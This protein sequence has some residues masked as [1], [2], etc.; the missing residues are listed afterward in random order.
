MLHKLLTNGAGPATEAGYPQGGWPK[1]VS[2][3]K[4]MRRTAFSRAVPPVLK[5]NN[6][7]LTSTIGMTL[8]ELL[9]VLSVIA[10]VV[11]LSTPALVRYSGQ[12]RLKS[13]VRQVVGLLSLV[14]S[15]SVSSP[16]GHTVSIDLERRELS[17]V[18][19]D[20]GE[21]LEQIVR[22]PRGLEVAVEAG[23]EALKP[24]ELVFQPN[25][26][27]RGR[28]VS[29]IL[30]DKDKDVTITVSSITGAVTVN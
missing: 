3:A 13:T 9:V 24:P 10:A 2:H 21:A 6:L 4:G 11:G 26:A 7:Y 18:D 17:V 16:A 22:L 15:L 5:V 8:M 12:A 30:T 25:G 29:L 19:N 27:L 1:E 20:S 28:T 23:G 14:R